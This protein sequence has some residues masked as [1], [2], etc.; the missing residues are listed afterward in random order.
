MLN[1][2]NIFVKYG[3]RTLLDYINL[4]IKPGERIGLV[5]RNGAGKST[6]LKIIAEEMSP[7]EG[8]VVKPTHFTIGYL[9]QDM[10]LPKGKNCAGRD[11]DSIC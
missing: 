11:D 6:L 7:H 2:S 10:L 5:G 8:N 1:L 3:D 9:H 4:V